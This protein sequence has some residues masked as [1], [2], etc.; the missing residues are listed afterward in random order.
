MDLPTNLWSD[1]AAR[2][3]VSQ[4][5]ELFRDSPLILTDRLTNSVYVN[6]PAAALLGDR[7]EALV[8]RTAFSLLGLG[9]SEKMPEPLE[10]ALLGDGP[11]WRGIVRLCKVDNP[12]ESPHI[13]CEASAINR[14][15]SHV[16]G[17]LRLTPSAAPVAS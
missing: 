10:K 3:L 5:V 13:F 11:P 6:E 1:D 8:N 2:E 14:H 4:T 15:G 12:D 17:I 9:V 7:G 16:C